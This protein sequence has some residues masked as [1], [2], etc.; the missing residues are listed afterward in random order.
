MSGDARGHHL[1]QVNVARSRTPLDAEELADFRA[2]LDPVNA[3][4]D[5]Q[6]G[7]VWR[8]QDDDGSAMGVRAFGDEQMIVNLSAWASIEA[9]WSFV[10]AGGH[11]AAM[12]RRREWFE[13]LGDVHLALWWIPAGTLPTVADA[14]RRVARLEADGPS[15]HAFDF[16]RRFDP[17]G[18]S[19]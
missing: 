8:L 12:R 11:L 3:L 10:Y 15:P 18:R 6:P 4:A 19:I 16:K 1:A 2:L 17:A 9:L 7:F 14:E 13:R 5:G